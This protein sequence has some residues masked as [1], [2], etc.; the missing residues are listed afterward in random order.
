MSDE[1]E[2]GLLDK[3]GIA[4]EIRNIPETVVLRFLKGTKWYRD[5]FTFFGKYIRPW[6]MRGQTR[7]FDELLSQANRMAQIA[8]MDETIR[9]AEKKIES[10]CN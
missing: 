8:L 1:V 9:E 6:L 10:G 4:V 3:M 7:L 2:V 5:R